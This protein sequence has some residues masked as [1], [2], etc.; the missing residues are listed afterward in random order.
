MSKQYAISIL[1][2][3]FILLLMSC[4]KKDQTCTVK[5]VNGIKEYHNN[6]IPADPELK[7][8]PKLL[9]SISR[10]DENISDSTRT[11]KMISSISADSKNNIYLLDT[12]TSSVKKFDSSGKYVKSFGRTGT[13]PG[14][15]VQP[16][17]M[18]VFND[19]IYVM[20]HSASRMIRFD[21]NGTFINNLPVQGGTPQ[22]LRSTGSNNFLGF[23]QTTRNEDGNFIIS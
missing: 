13:G 21:N 20:D 3:I 15:S 19:T 23:K 12:K 7:I 11:L 14:E 8:E 18:A 5:D 16:T 22:F 17:N 9:F 4:T 2:A 6:N 10:E 1:T